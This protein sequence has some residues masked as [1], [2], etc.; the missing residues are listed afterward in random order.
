MKGY[1]FFFGVRITLESLA[2]FRHGVAHGTTSLPLEMRYKHGVC[3]Q[4]LKDLSCEK[5]VH[6]KQCR[7]NDGLQPV[8]QRNLKPAEAIVEQKA[9]N[10]QQEKQ[11]K[12]FQQIQKIK[13]TPHVLKAGEELWVMDDI[14]TVLGHMRRPDLEDHIKA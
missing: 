2:N 14:E 5:L 9:L 1:R 8:L 13:E 7:T 12:V 11:Q 4:D 3:A 10:R 6:G